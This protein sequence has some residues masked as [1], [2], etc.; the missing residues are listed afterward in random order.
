M[1]PARITVEELK[2]RIDQGEQ[3]FIID[4]RSPAAW[5]ESGVKLPGA[6]RMHFNELENHIKELPG[7]QI[8]VA[9]CT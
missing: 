7:D 9:Y 8:I 4:T 1:E 5:Y 6:V 3:I 2:R